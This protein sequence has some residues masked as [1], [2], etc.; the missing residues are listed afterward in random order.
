MSTSTD[1]AWL[2]MGRN[3]PGYDL[4]WFYAFATNEEANTFVEAAMKGHPGAILWDVGNTPCP[5]DTVDEALAALR[6][7]IEE[8]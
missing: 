6:T 2:V 8:D 1:T 5:I 4:S 3:A 7:A